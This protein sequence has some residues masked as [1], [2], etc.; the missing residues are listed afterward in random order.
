MHEALFISNKQWIIWI[1]YILLFEFCLAA[2]IRSLEVTLYF[3]I[4][5]SPILFLSQWYDSRPYFLQH[6]LM[7]STYIPF[8]VQ[9]FLNCIPSP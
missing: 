1:Q 5:D 7:F 8:S 3:G 4:W 9:M 6:F 2:I